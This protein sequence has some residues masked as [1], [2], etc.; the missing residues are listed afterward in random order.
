[1]RILKK[2]EKKLL[3]RCPR[4]KEFV[5]WERRTRKSEEEAN[6]HLSYTEEIIAFFQTDKSLSL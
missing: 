1:M 5:K 2:R 3:Q 4:G 6:R